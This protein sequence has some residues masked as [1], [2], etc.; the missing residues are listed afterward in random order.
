MKEAVMK[1]NGPGKREG[2]KEKAR[3]RK[4]IENESNQKN[5]NIGVKERTAFKETVT[6]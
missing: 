5:E 6:L 4:Q 2:I 3:K 1:G